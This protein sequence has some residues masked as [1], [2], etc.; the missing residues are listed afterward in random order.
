MHNFGEQ[1]RCIMGPGRM[2]SFWGFAFN[3]YSVKTGLQMKIHTN[4]CEQLDSFVF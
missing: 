1:M 3:P 4:E 2:L